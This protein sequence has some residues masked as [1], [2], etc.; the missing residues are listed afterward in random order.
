MLISEVVEISVLSNNKSFLKER[1]YDISKNKVFVSIC[2]LTKYSRAIVIVKCDVCE[3]QKETT[4]YLY[5]KNAN[6]GGFYVCEK[7]GCINY[8]RKK[9]NIER[10]GYEW[11][12]KNNEI[13]EKRK[14]TN[15]DKYG[16]ECNLQLNHV[17]E[18]VKKSFSDNI[19]QI[20]YKKEKTNLE[21]YGY[22]SPLSN[23]DVK[24]KIK[25]TNFEKYGVENVMK[26]N[27]IVEKGKNSKKEKWGNANYNNRNKA[28]LTNIERY[29]V[30]SFSQ[31]ELYLEK[32][33][34]TNL[35]RYGTEHYSKTDEFKSKVKITSL[36]KYGFDNYTK[37]KEYLEK[38]KL[39]NLDKYGV[40]HPMLSSSIR[41]KIEETNIEKYGV[42]NYIELDEVR[43]IAKKSHFEKTKK[44]AIETYSKILPID[45]TI[46]D[47]SYGDFLL[48]HND[49][50]FTI[51]VK[52][53][54]DRNK[55]S[56][57]SEICT[58]CNPIGS[59][60]SSNENEISKWLSS[61]DLSIENGN[62]KIL[63]NK[64][65]L[66]IYLPNHN[67]AIEFNGLYWHS[68]LFK[69]KY[70]HLTKT[71][72]CKEVGIKLLHIF[73]DDWE[74]KKDI[75]KSIIL[76]SIG[77]I[78]NKIYARKCELKFVN[79]TDS[80]KFLDENHIQGYSRCKYRVGL[81]HNSELVSLMT[82][83]YR[84][85]NNK[86]EFELIRFCN[87]INYN[88][89]GSASKLFKYFIE[90]NTEI[91]DRIV[92]YADISLFDGKI[93]KILGFEQIHLTKPNYFWVVGNKK[94]HRFKFNKKKL[95]KDGF[96]PNK[97]EYEIMKDRGYYK[98]WSCG[99][100]RFEFPM[101]NYR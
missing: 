27:S 26:L 16:V 9:R 52:L 49:H 4:Y 36:E 7:K 76:N 88:I 61:L 68:D 23:D 57:H 79:S 40:V 45:Y 35:E 83:G 80:R 75:V 19:I 25:N 11:S 82:F 77:L 84:K 78:N 41:S 66:D 69:N 55:Y 21:R 72:L 15:L 51:T 5:M 38:S 89:I 60:S 13:K 10:Y 70:Y 18:K 44:Y 54:Y 96:D 47:Y 33:K 98:I 8:K 100:I 2:D 34:E 65:E 22:K 97:T 101:I 73:E 94:Y 42:R 81:F 93:Y 99:Q 31:T 28:I 87:K 58:V 64:Q 59:S 3:Q 62:R 29:G 85:I 39:T 53:I 12:S 95:I 56:K 48:K 17:K 32:S 86:K 20:N 67:L 37:T 14:K 63:H 30:E 71:N 24:N 43:E 92:S 46:L 50:E 91:F 74:N 90:N 6:N 1:G